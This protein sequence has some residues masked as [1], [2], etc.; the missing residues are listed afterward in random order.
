MK[1][2]P[3]LVAAE[4]VPARGRPSLRPLAALAILG[5]LVVHLGTE[6]FLDGLRSIDAL[7]IVAALAIGGVTTVLSAAR[8]VLVARR[9]G[10]PLSLRTAVR[11]YYRSQFLNAVLPAG[12]LGDVHRAVGHGRASGDIGRAARA[13]FFERL[14]GQVVLVAVVVVAVVLGLGMPTAFPALDLA[15]GRLTVAVVLAGL[16]VIVVVARRIERVRRILVDTLADGGRLLSLRTWPAVVALSAAVTAGYLATFLVAARAAGSDAAI[17]R[18]AAIL[19]PALLIMAIPINIGG[20][21]PRE[22]FLA[23]AFGSAGLG[24]AQGVTTG[25]VYG[26]LTLIAAAPG[27]VVLL[28]SHRTGV[29]RDGSQ[30]VAERFDQPG[31]QELP[32]GR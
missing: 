5:A 12:V 15:P 10:L 8:W 18:L 22:A 32:L 25:V 20:F 30:V 1:R 7:S 14:A 28:W 11:D 31:E 13:V 2:Q 21:G 24:A 29:G 27:A 4:L 6:P 17:T 3:A 23:M 19:L 26:V 16:V 9:L